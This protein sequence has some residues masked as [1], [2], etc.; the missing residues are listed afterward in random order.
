MKKITFL[1]F[2]FLSTS[3]CIAQHSQ[4]T[5]VFSPKSELNI[6]GSS[7]VNNF[8]CLFETQ[9]LNQFPVAYNKSKDVIRLNRATLVLPNNHF[10]CG[11]RGINKDFHSLLQTQKYPEIQLTLK[12]I[13]R[14]PNVSNSV[15]A[16]VDIKIAGKTKSY[17]LDARYNQKN[18]LNIFGKL[19][20]SLNDFG[21]T[22]P[23][24]LMGLIV[25]SDQIEIDFNLFVTEKS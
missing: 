3:F 20:L 14:K 15:E 21:L 22:A 1:F 9:K 18:E 4:K 12:Q 11:G 23:K 6:K 13:K 17:V 10:D 19:K 8:Q 24:K 16:V 25:V 2:L 7:N 5:F